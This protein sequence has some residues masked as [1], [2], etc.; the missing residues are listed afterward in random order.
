M[1]FHI[2]SFGWLGQHGPFHLP[3]KPPW[4][5]FAALD[6]TLLKQGLAAS[7]LAVGL[8]LLLAQF[9]GGSE[10]L[11]AL[12]GVSSL[13]YLGLLIESCP[14]GRALLTL[15]AIPLI[16]AFSY[17]S[18]AGVGAFL[19]GAFLLHAV[20]AAIQ[21]PRQNKE[22]KAQLFS[23]AAYNACLGLLLL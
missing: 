22:R 16:F 12:A 5:P 15:I 17:A 2:K 13:L 1:N 19:V 7:G 14:L 4:H 21:F 20:V 9:S 10:V 3:G 18:L 23:W 11:A 6:R 8:Y